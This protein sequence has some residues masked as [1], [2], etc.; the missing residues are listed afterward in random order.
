MPGTPDLARLADRLAEGASLAPAEF[1][2]L[3]DAVARLAAGEVVKPPQAATEPATERRAERDRLLRQLHRWHYP[4]LRPRP[5]AER[6]V[7]DLQRYESAGW[8]TDRNS[9]ECP[10]AETDR[11][12][13]FLAIL[14][15]G[16]RVL[17]WRQI[18]E[19]CCR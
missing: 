18:L 2:W 9:A 14:R 17:R 13:L 6:I 15:T 8:L 7:R 11:R 19:I 1:E 10:Y 12:A 16:R 4:N 3:S 5:A